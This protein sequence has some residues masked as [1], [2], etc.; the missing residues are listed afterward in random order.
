MSVDIGGPYPVGLPVTDQ[1]NIA[2]HRYPKY[3]LAGAFIPFSQKE[4]LDHYNQE[5]RDRQATGLQ[6]PVPK[7]EFT[8]QN[9]P[10]VYFVELMAERSE[11]PHALRKM[12]NKIEYMHKCKAVYRVHADRAPELTGDRAKSYL[13]NNGVMVTS[14][15]GYD[16]NANG[17]AER[18]VQFFQ[19]RSR[20]LLCTNTV[21]YTHLRA[22]ET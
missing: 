14:T 5:L 10:S 4:A 21:S 7:I 6:G 3:L 22:H 11:A 12:I 13:E 18:A 19:T 17:R 8:K 20:T 9:S 1:P 15:A 16:S 2:R